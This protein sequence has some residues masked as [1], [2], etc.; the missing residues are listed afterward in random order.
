MYSY[1]LDKYILPM[2]DRLLGLTIQRELAGWRRW[3]W[4]SRTDLDRIQ[5]G[6]L[7]DLL[8]HSSERIPYYSTVS[9]EVDFNPK[10]DPSHTLKQFPILDKPLI[11]KNLPDRIIDKSR[12]IYFIDYTSGSSGIQGEFYSD[13]AAYSRMQA[14][15]CLW[16]EWAGYRFGDR[17]LQTGITPRRGFIKGMKDF[18]LRVEY[19]SAYQ[20]DDETIERKL[21]PLREGTHTWVFAG[22]AASLYAYARYARDHGID[23]IRFKTVIS[24]GDKMFPHYRTCIEDQFRSKV[25]DCYGASEG[26]MIAAECE[27]HHYHIM[28]PHVFI[29]I[30]DKDGREVAPGEMGEVVV[31]RLDNYLMP[32]IRYR[33]GDLAVKSNPA[34]EC[35]CGRQL[36]LL[37][38][39]VGRDTDLVYTPRGKTLI[40]HFFTGVFEYRQEIQQ[41]Q[42]VQHALDDI[43][44]K[45]IPSTDFKPECLDSIKKDIWKKADEKFNV[46]FTEVSAIGA[47]PSGKP[48][49]IESKYSKT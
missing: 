46:R 17:V 26:V 13:K 45:Y 39:I 5:K 21:R 40:V 44:I 25:F 7:Q 42:I 8:I 16:W 10:Q 20:I 2:T 34:K 19:A 3:Q 15:Q 4:Y 29:E 48:Q 47:S 9:K 14:V 43:E 49:I 1:F 18:L 24:W 35:P 30:L 11:K 37:E 33:I 28:T 31:T 32:L 38:M 41:F 23:D 22:Y 12:K 27:E 36:S 6:R